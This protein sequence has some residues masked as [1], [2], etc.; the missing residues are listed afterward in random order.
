M[1]AIARLTTWSD[2]LSFRPFIVP[3]DVASCLVVAT[4]SKVGTSSRPSSHAVS[5]VVGGTTSCRISTGLVTL[6]GET[7]GASPEIRGC[8]LRPSPTEQQKRPHADLP[9]MG[10]AV[11]A[12]MSDH[13]PTTVPRHTPNCLIKLSRWARIGVLRT[14]I[15]PPFVFIRSRCA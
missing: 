11:Q 8:P 9:R 6:Q 14:S 1:C 12:C 5:M 7:G 10:T 4:I 2:L 15:M 13:Q 3:S